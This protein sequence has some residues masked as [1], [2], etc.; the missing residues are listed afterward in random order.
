LFTDNG[1]WLPKFLRWR[2]GYYRPRSRTGK[3]RRHQTHHAAVST[4]MNK[5]TNIHN[6]TLINKA[7]NETQGKFDFTFVFAF[8]KKEE[9]L[10]FRRFWKLNYAELS[11][12]IRNEK[13]LIK[14]TMRNREYA[15]K[16]QSDTLHLG[17]LATMQLL[18][19][20]AAKHEANRQ[21]LAA[22]QMAK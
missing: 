4:F 3:K 16:L 7:W 13:T 12:T 5:Q 8:Q 9:Y 15:G 21:Y 18:M 11:A 1:F 19:L 14:T 20:Q 6:Q 10:E 22:K 2:A 17:A